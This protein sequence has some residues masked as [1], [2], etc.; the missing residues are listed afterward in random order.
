MSFIIEQPPELTGDNGNDL[1]ALR[2]YISELVDEL[3]YRLR[4]V[5]EE[6]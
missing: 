2:E 4:G 5:G 3:E 6:K 1:E